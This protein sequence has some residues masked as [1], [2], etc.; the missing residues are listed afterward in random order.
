MNKSGD[1]AGQAVMKK[2]QGI[3]TSDFQTQYS[4]VQ[5]SAVQCS[6]KWCVR[7]VYPTVFSHTDRARMHSRIPSLTCRDPPL[8]L[9]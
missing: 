6:E 3:R 9:A 7:V 8:L 2:D 5:C 4:A 1:G